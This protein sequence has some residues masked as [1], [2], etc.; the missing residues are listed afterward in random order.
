M[1]TKTEEIDRI[2][3]LSNG[4]VQVRKEAVILEDDREV[5]RS[6]ERWVLHPGDDLSGQD[7]R[8]RRVV[9]AAWRGGQ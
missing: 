5:S 4:T 8:V 3:V 2:E 9:E 7:E 6:Y 1:L